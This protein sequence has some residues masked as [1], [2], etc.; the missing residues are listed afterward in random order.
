VLFNNELV[1]VRDTEILDYA[2]KLI[3]DWNVEIVLPDP[4]QYA[5]N[6]ALYERGKTIHKLFTQ[7]GGVEKIKYIHNT[8]RHFEQHKIYIPMKYQK[9]IKS[10]K[11]LTYN[12]KGRIRKI[13]DH[14]AGSF[15]L[16][17]KA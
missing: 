8:K 17:G 11:Q 2:E 7:Y 10:L 14:S 1:G 16:R 15:G 13:N 9:L 3:K 4:A 6:N 5:M 12:K